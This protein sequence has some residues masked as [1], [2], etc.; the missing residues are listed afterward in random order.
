MRIYRLSNISHYFPQPSQEF[1]THQHLQRARP[2]VP[3]ILLEFMLLLTSTYRDGSDIDDVDISTCMCKN[4]YYSL[5]YML[6]SWIETCKLGHASNIYLFTFLLGRFKHRPFRDAY[7]VAII[8]VHRAY[9][10][11]FFMLLASCAFSI[12]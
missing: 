12:S 1:I 4:N 7:F 5:Y 2:L 6:C 10:F 3:A 9:S 11:C 8:P